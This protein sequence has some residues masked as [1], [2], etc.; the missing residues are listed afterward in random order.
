MKINIVCAGNRDFIIPMKVMLK[1][2]AINTKK[3]VNVFVL[4]KEWNKEDKI[5]FVESFRNSRHITIKFI[6]VRNYTCLQHL[7]TTP[8]IPIE[9]YFRL[10]LP[11]ILPE[12]IEEIIYLDGDV[13]VEGDIGDLWKIPMRGKALMAVPEM[14][15]EAYY[16]S[17]PLAL[18]TYKKLNIPDKNVYFNSG[19]LKI[20]IKK[21]KENNIAEKIIEYLIEN[22]DD[23]L[24]HDQDGLNAVLWNDWGELPGEWNV[25]TALFRERDVSKIGMT[26]ETA[27]Y[28][29]E[30]PQ[31]IHYTNS[32]EKPWKETCT[33]PL[34]ERYFYYADM[35][36]ER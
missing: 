2:L 15:H 22:K 26:D 11:E 31:I 27:R 17:G 10:L 3:N 23:V 12:N 6:D 20:N 1:S 35:I 36:K 25:M 29:M 7:K 16:V 32:K 19:V 8:N 18:H 24:W 33:H 28:V 14:F 30:N 34:K 4:I 9:A 13:I 5:D 21:W